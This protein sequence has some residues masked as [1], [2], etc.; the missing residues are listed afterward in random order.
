MIKA[1]FF[2]AFCILCCF[3]SI[4]ICAQQIV[5]ST[6]NYREVINAADLT[7]PN[8]AGSNLNSS[9]ETSAAFTRLDIRNIGSTQGWKVVISRQD[10]TWNNALTIFIQ[11]TSDGS[12]CVTCDGVTSSISPLNTYIPLQA[13]QTDF[14]YGKGEVTGID[15][16]VRVDG[17]SVLLPVDNYRTEIM[18]TLYGE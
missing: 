14:I 18:Y 3:S 8:E 12:P 15:L 4:D 13:I 9:I 17:L 6:F 16:Q 7:T 5:S 10:I 1:R 11:R 2:I